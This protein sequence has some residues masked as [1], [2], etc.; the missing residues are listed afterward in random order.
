MQHIGSSNWVQVILNNLLHFQSGIRE[1]LADTGDCIDIREQ[2]QAIN[3]SSFIVP[4]PEL[5]IK[6]NLI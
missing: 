2:I 4:K 1:S 6:Y 5:R 3:L